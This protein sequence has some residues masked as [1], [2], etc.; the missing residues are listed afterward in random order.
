[1]QQ[2]TFYRLPPWSSTGWERAV[3]REAGRRPFPELPVPRFPDNSV[4]QSPRSISSLA[5]SRTTRHAEP[6]GEGA[7]VLVTVVDDEAAPPDVVPDAWIH[8]VD[9]LSGRRAHV[10][11]NLR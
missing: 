7:G 3:G 4:A 10:N 6:D 5:A 8:F 9:D 1:M 2:R 11:G